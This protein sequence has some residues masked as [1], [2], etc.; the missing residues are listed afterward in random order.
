MQIKMG[1]RPTF[2]A[3][4]IKFLE[5]YNRENLHN[6]RFDNDFLDT[7]PKHRQHKKKMDKLG[8]Q[9]LKLV[10]Q[11]QPQNGRNLQTTYLIQE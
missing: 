4:T 8:H 2:R 6:I 7:I 3:K 9:N 10:H 5:E 11:K 1:Q